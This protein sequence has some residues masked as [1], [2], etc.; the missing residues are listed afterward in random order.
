[1]QL[2]GFGSWA[3]G[4]TGNA[5]TYLQGN[6]EGN[7]Q[8][9]S[10]AVNVSARLGA[11][12]KIVAQEFFVDDQDSSEAVLDFAFAEWGISDRLK[13]RVGKIKHPFGISTEVFDVGTLRPFI[14]LPQAVYGPIGL[15]AEAYKGVGVT[16][17]HP[18][19]RRWHLS[20]D[21]YAGGIDVEEF[22]PPEAFLRGEPLVEGIETE[23]RNTKDMIGGRAALETPVDGLRFGFSAYT[24]N[25]IESG[26]RI[27]YG[28]DIE[29]LSDRWSIRSEYAHKT[30]ARDLR[31]NATYVEIAYRFDPRWQAALQ[32]DHLTT[33]LAD[34]DASI[35]P[36]L[37]D[38]KEGAAGLNYWFSPAFVLKLSF[39][40]VEGNRFAAPE[41]ADLSAAVTSGSLRTRTN[42][43]VFGGQFSF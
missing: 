14:N 2:H 20:Y 27:V 15:V 12:L 21:L 18:L 36:S 26:H 1:M 4:Q 24:G 32:Y 17:S 11:K 22:V 25:E 10:L 28:T 43:I 30:V 7:Y 34:V 37:L 39:H 35:A 42:L 40:R 29:Y 13:L 3:Y 9:S 19:G 6:P 8:D 41:P 5:N 38:H 33:R 23:R 16:G 31:A